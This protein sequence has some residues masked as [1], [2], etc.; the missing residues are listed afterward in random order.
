MTKPNR[1]L[2]ALSLDSPGAWIAAWLVAA[3]VFALLLAGCGGGVSSGGTGTYAAGPITGFG[4]VIVNGV[5]YDD[6]T[7]AVVDED[8]TTRSR[9]DLKLGMTV[10]ID[11]DAIR[12]D[13][14]G[15]AATAR[16]IR[17]GSEIVGP[18][19]AVD[20]AAGTLTVLGQ[21]VRIVAD[22]VFD[23][24]LAGGLAGMNP[25]QGVEVFALYDASTGRYDAT[26]VES[27]T[28]LTSWRLRGPV[29]ALDTAA[30]TLRIGAAE[31]SDAGAAAVPA[32]LANGTIV[33]LQLATSRDVAG[34]YV[35]V[36]FG[37]GVRVPEDR[38]EA[39]LKGRVSAFTSTADFEVG[40]VRIDGSAAT[41]SGAASALRLGARVEVKGATV[42]GVLR[43][44]SV[45]VETEDEARDEGFELS[46]LIGAVDAAARTFTLRG[47]TV[48]WA[49]AGLVIEGGTLADIQV[50][51]KVQVKAQLSADRTQLEA[52]RIEFD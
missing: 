31:L 9:A 20:V 16:Q 49:R 11:S 50:G 17:F 41:I 24:R 27:K 5:R 13:A 38:E 2:A 46:G 42:G 19:T 39:E 3:L 4:S 30:R 44:R 26:R 10:A 52:T 51:R 36:S 40:G 21:T 33:R 22:T 8:D 7:A 34:R 28:G 47:E 29:S 25:G 43:A 18:V 35:V 48:S 6:S 23:E 15:R 32:G 45:A 37:V 14:A 12:A 1:L